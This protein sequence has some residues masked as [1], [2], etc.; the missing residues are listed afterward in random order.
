MK[1]FIET[2]NF[3]Y[4][5]L[6]LELYEKLYRLKKYINTCKKFDRKNSDDRILLLFSNSISIIG[7]EINELCCELNADLHDN[8]K[9]AI[10]LN[11]SKNSKAISKIHEELKNLHS[12]WILPEIKTFTNEITSGEIN[13]PK[14]TYIILSDNYTFLERNLGKKF[15]SELKGVYSRLEKPSFLQE[16]H[17][18]IIPK[19]EFSNPLNWT[20]LVHEA[21]HLHS[22]MIKA[23]RD[24]PAIMPDNIQS[25]NE[26]IIK[27]WAEEIFCDIYSISI[28]GP[29]YFIS[30]VSF[31]LLSSLDYGISADS[32]LHPAVVIRAS[33]MIHYLKDN[34]LLFKSEWGI[35]DYTDIFYNWLINQSYIYRDRA[36]NTIEGL[37]KFNRN[38]RKII[39]ELDLC[40]FSINE[41]E[42][43]NIKNLLD[44]LNKGVPI[45]SVCIE[46]GSDS[47]EILKKANLNEMEIRTLK[48]SVSE[49]GCKIWEILNT[50]WIYKLEQSCEIGEQI[51]FG[52][53]YQNESIMK[54]INRYGEEIDF[55]DERLLASINTSQIIKIIEQE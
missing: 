3:L 33:I 24:N 39:K 41:V 53:K 49:R 35:E 42:S 20:I 54:K 38:L 17:S 34:N 43:K 11:I 27:N 22:D 21:G 19:I 4:K 37:T 13:S 50:G 47:K 32:E 25:L 16:N 30:F 12:S 9:F 18:F 8:D 45:G 55:L 2:D 23:I 29:A 28:L 1:K 15:E 26:K 6:I 36:E 40:K 7:D 48:N 46:N 52:E 51:F 14:D 10:I 31:A 5:Y 44:K